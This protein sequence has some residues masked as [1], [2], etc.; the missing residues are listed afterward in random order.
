ME[1]SSKL[2]PYST[3][4]LAFAYFKFVALLK[5]NRRCFVFFLSLS[6]VSRR[7]LFSLNVFADYNI[8]N[9]MGNLINSHQQLLDNNS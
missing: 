3:D 1:N 4:F 7:R 6:L 8:N 2:I 9:L 5:M